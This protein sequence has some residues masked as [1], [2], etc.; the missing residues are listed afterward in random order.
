M[1]F[2]EIMKRY[3][4]LSKKEDKEGDR[5]NFQYGDA[6]IEMIITKKGKTKNI[7]EK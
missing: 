2:D 6:G 5:M 1:L 7:K 3:K 4:E